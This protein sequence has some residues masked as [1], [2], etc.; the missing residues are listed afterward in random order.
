MA[1]SSS[2]GEGKKGEKDGIVRPN[3]REIEKFRQI[4]FADRNRRERI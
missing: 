2:E 3:E 1:R 4:A